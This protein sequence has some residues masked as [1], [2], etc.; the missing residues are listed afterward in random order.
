[1]IDGPPSD[2]GKRTNLGRGL[3]ALFGEENEDYASLDKVRSS[4]T[5]PIEHL[6]PGRFQP[7]H[8][9][10]EAAVDALAES[11]KA[12]GIL[13][14]ILVRRHPDRPNDFE[15]VAGRSEERRVGEEGV[16]TCRSRGAQ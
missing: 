8:H 2:Q 14:P 6:R 3:A 10:D 9:F 15:L 4:K 7:R 5:V 1:M 12:Q 11:I 16:S 13:Q